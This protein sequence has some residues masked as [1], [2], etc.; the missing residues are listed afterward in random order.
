[1]NPLQ[2][3]VVV[4]GLD[5]LCAVIAAEVKKATAPIA[6]RLDATAQAAEDAG[7]KAMLTAREVSALLRV[8]P[9]ELRRLVRE[10]RFPAPV[11][12]GARSIRWTPDVVDRAMKGGAS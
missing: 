5:D 11:K 7:P 6:A 1:M 2:G 8:T 4:V 9:R 12:V 10:G 3:S